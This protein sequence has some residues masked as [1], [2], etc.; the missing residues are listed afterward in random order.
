MN[1][2]RLKLVLIGVILGFVSISLASESIVSDD[3]H[4]VATKAYAL[5][6]Q[7]GKEEVIVVYDIDNTLLA[8]NQRLGSDQWFSWQAAKITA[9][10]LTDAVAKDIPGLL[11]VQGTLYALGSMHAPDKETPAI[12]NELQQNGFHNL[13]LTSRGFDFRDAT[14][15]ELSKNGYHFGKTTIHPQEGFAGTYLPYELSNISNYGLSEDDVKKFK[16]GNPNPVSFMDGIFMT[17]GQHKGVML[18]TLLW[19]TDHLFKA[20]LFVDDQQKHCTRMHDAFD[21]QGVDVV[22]IRYSKEDDH[23][24]EF[25]LS[26]KSQVIEEWE[27]LKNILST[28]F[29]TE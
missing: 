17:A 16:L 4:V 9:G 25:E 19:K 2:K 7:Y 23:V 11:S 21:S 28:L 18:R 29:G 10:D 6:E 27:I 5:A 22:T 26:D 14:L 12:V 1:T 20:I 24:K 15:R 8:M 13:V 3:F